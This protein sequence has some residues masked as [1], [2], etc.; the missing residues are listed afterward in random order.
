M[1]LR[2]P[3]HGRRALPRL[4]VL[5]AAAGALLCAGV[6]GAGASGRAVIDG[7][8]AGRIAAGRAAGDRA[9]GDRAAGDRALADPSIA[10]QAPGPRTSGPQDPAGV[11]ARGAYLARLGN[12]EGCHSTPGS[13]AYAGGR[14]LPTPFGTVYP[15]N[16]TP[17]AATGLG[18]WSADEFWRA[19]HEGRS[20]D[21]RRLVPAFPYTAFTRLTR[22]DSD[23]LHA[24]LQTLP[25][26]AQ[27]NRPH[28]L[29]F[30]YGTQF[31]LWAWQWLFFEP[32][33]A[34]PAAAAQTA[35]GE[36]LVRA[37][38]HCT[39]C[40]SPRNALGA[41]DESL[42]GGVMPGQGWYAPPLRLPPGAEAP[43]ADF[44]Q[45]LRT[46]RNAHGSAIGPMAAV[47]HRSTQYWS[48]A[49]LEAAGRYL[50]SLPPLDGPVRTAAAAPVHLLLSG[51]RLYV[52][53]C[54]DCHGKDGRGVAG[55][56]SPLAGN[57]TVLQPEL[58]NLV[59]MLHYGG[60]APSTA[61][62]PRP[63]GMPPQ[64]LSDEQAAA[65]VSY[66]RQA[67]GNGAPAASALDVM[68]AR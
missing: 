4:I 51:E 5:L 56:Y 32:A 43:L 49:D 33:P 39:A 59:K 28:A 22:A 25:A 64:E 18:R 53:R 19:L 30:P 66:V 34:T 38:G 13:R 24:Y 12:C 58:H 10:R 1:N 9:A 2:V 37:I 61:A 41:E 26:V 44:V 11:V 55:V 20:R 60:F 27:P 57:P 47:V 8:A 46:G 45:L 15:G 7:S 29:R 3:P 65:L 63:Y 21:G 42:A 40:H 50:Q 68:R 16:L 52:E 31:A 14:G 23:A 6:R 62:F 48:D 67:W 36:Y 54:A 35:R 17:D